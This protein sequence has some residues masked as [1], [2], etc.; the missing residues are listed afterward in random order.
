VRPML[1]RCGW[2]LSLLVSVSLGCDASSPEHPQE[3]GVPPSNEVSVECESPSDCVTPGA[4]ERREGVACTAGTCVYPPVVCDDPP[5]P[6]CSEND[7]T[8]RTFASPG[9]CNAGVCEYTAMEQPCESCASQCLGACEGVVCDALEFGCRTS[10]ACMPGDSG[11]PATCVYTV[12]N[13][14]TPC[15]DDDPCTTAESCLSGVCETSPVPDGMSCEGEEGTCE[16]GECIECI[17]DGDCND[18]NSCTEDRCGDDNRCTYTA[19]DGESC[20]DGDLC[21]QTDTCNSAGDCIGTAPV[22]CAPGECEAAS[23]CNPGTGLCEATLAAPGA[24]CDDSDFCTFN[25]RCNSS[26]GCAGTLIVCEDDPTTC[27]A[28]RSCNG[29]DSCSID[30]P[31]GSCNDVDQCTT[32]DS[33][34]GSGNC[35]GTAIANGEPCDGASGVCNA[36]LCRDCFDN[37]D[38]SGNSLRKTCDAGLCVECTGNS[39]CGNAECTSG[40]CSGGR[41]S[42]INVPGG[43]CGPLGSCLCGFDGDCDLTTCCGGPGQPACP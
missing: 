32:N 20:D 7:S 3:P 39:D 18:N 42:F 37:D 26:G 25:D 1:C 8:Y 16:S 40:V 31:V 14:A 11:A 22:S 19:R 41:C 21:T 24:S 6:E 38:C 27:G 35:T 13:D 9:T 36:G 43:A 29:S 12:V 5:E 15:D 28:R 10:G 30:F 17:N 4:C 33:C 23:S 34:D 2:V